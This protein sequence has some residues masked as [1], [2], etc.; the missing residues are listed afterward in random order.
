MF[1]TRDGTDH[2]HLKAPVSGIFSLSSIRQLEPII[3]ECTD[4]FIDEMTKRSPK[5]VDFSTWLQWYA[6]DVIGSI[7]FLARFGFMEQ[8]KDVEG[9]IEKLDTGLTYVST[10]CFVPELHKYLLGNP[11]LMKILNFIPA[12]RAKDP[13]PTILNVRG[14]VPRLI[15]KAKI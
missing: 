14:K 13:F 8:G 7:T 1:S 12:V 11:K 6:F 9:M 3:D 4:I 15:E 10:I 5:P 2:K